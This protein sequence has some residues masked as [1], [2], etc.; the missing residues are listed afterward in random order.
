MY[1]YYSSLVHNISNI[2][3]IFFQQMIYYLIFL[4][5]WFLLFHLQK[6]KEKWER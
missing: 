4:S 6:I 3:S 2:C 1:L 5:A